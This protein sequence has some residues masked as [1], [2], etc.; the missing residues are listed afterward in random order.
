MLRRTPREPD[1]KEVEMKVLILSAASLVL[2]L[3]GATAFTAATIDVTGRTADARLIVATM[4]VN[5]NDSLTGTD[6]A[7]LTGLAT[8]ALKETHRF[9]N[10]VAKPVV[11]RIN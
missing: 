8:S 11:T 4:L 5:I 2:L 3:A 6:N 1:P 7:D 9:Q 10:P